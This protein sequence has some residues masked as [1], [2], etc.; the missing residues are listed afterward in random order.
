VKVNK[1]FVN[2]LGF[3]SRNRKIIAGKQEYLESLGKTLIE[4]CL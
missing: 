1:M 2:M 4:P 3:M